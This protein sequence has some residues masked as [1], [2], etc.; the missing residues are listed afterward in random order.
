M[1][2]IIELFFYAIAYVLGASICGNTLNG[3]HT[4]G[5]KKKNLYELMFL[6]SEHV[7]GHLETNHISRYFSSTT[8]EIFGV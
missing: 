1:G 6:K 5:K 8:L 3:A 2:R 7:S 4:P